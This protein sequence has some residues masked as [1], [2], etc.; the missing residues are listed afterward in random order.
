MKFPECRGALFAPDIPD[1]WR[2]RASRSGWAPFFA[3]IRRPGPPSARR[4]PARSVPPGISGMSGWPG[5]MIVEI[6]FLVEDFHPSRVI[7][8]QQEKSFQDL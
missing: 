7:F 1:R 3:V 4:G 5:V 6:I 2:L 8:F